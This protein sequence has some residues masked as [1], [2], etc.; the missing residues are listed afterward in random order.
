MIMMV[1]KTILITFLLLLG[2]FTGNAQSK[3][4]HDLEFGIKAGANLA[5][6]KNA[7][8]KSKIGPLG[9]IFAEYKFAEKFSLRSEAM[10]SKQGAK[11]K[12][13]FE[14]VKL[15]YVNLLPA[16]ARF[17]PVEN[18]SIEGGPYVG[19]LLSKKGGSLSKSDYRKIDFGAAFGLGYH[20]I[21]DVE[22]GLRYYLG[23]RDITKTTG[24]IKN[25]IFQ[26]ALSYSF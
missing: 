4:G 19:L 7:D 3:T 23:L 16:L 17:Y 24:E 22:I 11:E 12:G 5:S 13:N 14:T 2:T 26:L 10:L 25:K 20:I 21:E 1:F 8:G 6:L 9:G 18:L 15:N